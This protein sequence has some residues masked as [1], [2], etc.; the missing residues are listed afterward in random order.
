MNLFCAVVGLGG[1]GAPEDI[2]SISEEN[3]RMQ[4]QYKK[5]LILETQNYKGLIVNCIKSP[6]LSYRVL[7]L[8]FA[9][10][11]LVL[12]MVR[13]QSARLDTYKLGGEQHTNQRKANFLLQLHLIF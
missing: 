13:D 5:G 9:G 6:N 12:L 4:Q 2:F 10:I 3:R 8:G 11:S 1:S 7:H